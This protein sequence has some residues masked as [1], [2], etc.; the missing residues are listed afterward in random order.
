M[1][2]HRIK[3]LSLLF[4]LG[5]ITPIC[6]EKL[7]W[8][9]TFDSQYGLGPHI[10]I[11]GE[12]HC[13]NIYQWRERGQPERVRNVVLSYDSGNVRKLW[14]DIRPTIISAYVSN[15]CRY[16]AKKVIDSI[17]GSIDS[18]SGSIVD[19]R[20]GKTL[21]SS[22]NLF[23]VGDL[24]FS[25][26][27]QYI[28]N[29]GEYQVHES[30]IERGPSYA[31]TIGG[32]R[33][34]PNTVP[35]GTPVYG[36]KYYVRPPYIY[37]KKGNK[38]W[39]LEPVDIPSEFAYTT[40][41]K[42]LET[43]YLGHGSDLNGQEIWIWILALSNNGTHFIAS[44]SQDEQVYLG[45]WGDLGVAKK[46]VLPSTG[47]ASDAFYAGERRRGAFS[48]DDSSIAILYFPSTGTARV[49][50]LGIDGKIIWNRN[51]EAAEEFKT[52]QTSGSQYFGQPAAIRFVGRRIVVSW[53]QSGAKDIFQCYA[54]KVLDASSGATIYQRLDKNLM[55]KPDNVW[56]P[57]SAEAQTPLYLVSDKEYVRYHPKFEGD[58]VIIEFYKGKLKGEDP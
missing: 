34:P 21:A 25:L 40:G 8:S 51:F 33:L 18:S 31:T 10:S 36:G 12:L 42:D 37:D 11:H 19:L 13:V 3:Y 27:G 45:E 23:G 22:E 24:S 28:F 50:L 16:V 4:L 6:A 54:S 46:V 30:S 55:R 5:P 14:E 15:D 56:R 35:A 2:P 58:K 53:A 7:I 48:P 41:K 47:A 57:D 20:T 26:D 32:K 17:S 29:S 39:K 1:T 44:D 49:S 38:L 9:G 43:P 52:C